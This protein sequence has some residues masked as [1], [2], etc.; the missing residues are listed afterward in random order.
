MPDTLAIFVNLYIVLSAIISLVGIW[1]SYR[2]AKVLSL[3]MFGLAVIWILAV[4]V[5]LLYYPDIPDSQLVVG[6]WVFFPI[7]IWSMYAIL[8]KY[9]P[10]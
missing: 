9:I 10:H 1:K 3:L 7:G 2:L 4:R 5:V 8:K 6:F